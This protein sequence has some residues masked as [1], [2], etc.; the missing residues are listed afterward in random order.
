MRANFLSGAAGFHRSFIVKL[1]IL[2][3]IFIIV[4]VILYIQF[5][6]NDD[7]KNALLRLSLEQRGRV[8]AEA[9]RPALLEFESESPEMLHDAMAMLGDQ[10][11]NLR[12][13]FR[14]ENAQE[15]DGFFYVAAS[16]PDLNVSLSKERQTLIERG[17]LAE[18]AKA[19]ARTRQQFLRFTNPAGQEELLT[20][21]TPLHLSNGCWV[22]MTSDGAAA[23][24]QSSIGRSFWQ[25]A[26]I[27]IAA[28][29][30]FLTAGLICWLI[31]D[32]WRGANQ[33]QKAARAIRL[34]G[35]NGA[36]F[37]KLNPIPELAGVAEDFDALVAA[38]SRSRQYI[39][40]AAE[41][42]AHALKAPLAVIMQ[43]VEPLKR[44]FQSVSGGS[45]RSIELI[46]RS[47]ARLCALVNAAR[48][49]DKTGAEIVYSQKR[50]M[51]M[52]KFLQRLLSSYG[53]GLESKGKKLRVSIEPNISVLANED[54]L[55]SVVENLLE[56]A[57]SYAPLDSV[58]EVDLKRSNGAVNFS[59]G[60][61]GPGVAPEDMPH[62][63]ERYFSRRSAVETN[64]ANGGSGEHFGL[65]LWIVKRNVES[66]GGR[67]L[68]R[69][70]AEKGFK[71]TVRLNPF[72]GNNPPGPSRERR[73]PQRLFR[74]FP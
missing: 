21:L 44:E 40:N 25:S 15:A 19:C 8:I 55:E 65:G 39:R 59:V 42:N 46:E 56:N 71:V 66:L 10:Q 41:E 23:F 34:Q 27:K 18:L 50:R 67:V 61:R 14:P 3:M 62:I 5:R 29:V 64:G 13:L 73:P 38:L 60:D 45:H 2:A 47:V 16:P 48:E 54:L 69:N 12:L 31:A 58:I 26:E 36:S 11:T 63:F 32:M 30:Y 22:V 6:A 49:L 70:R 35:V 17:V 72:H 20:S 28:L 9:L 24:L 4:P 33:F 51:D 37:S 74:Q 43:A 53:A 1:S 57:S 68:V 52:S 7:E